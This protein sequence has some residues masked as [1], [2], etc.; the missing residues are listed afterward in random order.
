MAPVISLAKQMCLNKYA[1]NMTT[2]ILSPLWVVVC[3]LP[4]LF[5]FFSHIYNDFLYLLSQS[6]SVPPLCQLI[7]PL[8]RA[9]GTGL[10][11]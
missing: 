4:V 8:S 1:F 10:S 5:F 7:S 3:Q 11:K 9:P 2:K 6:N